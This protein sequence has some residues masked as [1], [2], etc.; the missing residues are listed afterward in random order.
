MALRGPQ[1]SGRQQQGGDLEGD[2]AG[3]AGSKPLHSMEGNRRGDQAS[4]QDQQQAG[5]RAAP[6]G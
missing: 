1:T 4:H 3:V 5:D 6:C 2:A